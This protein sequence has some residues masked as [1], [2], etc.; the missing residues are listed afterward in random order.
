MLA[1]PPDV[2]PNLPAPDHLTARLP[3]LPDHLEDKW[4]LIGHIHWCLPSE[5]Y[6]R[7]RWTINRPFPRKCDVYDPSYFIVHPGVF[8]PI[9]RPRYISRSSITS[10]GYPMN[11]SHAAQVLEHRSVVFAFYTHSELQWVFAEQIYCLTL[12]IRNSSFGICLYMVVHGHITGGIR[13]QI[14][15]SLSVYLKIWAKETVV[16]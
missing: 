5:V 14:T 13:C 6:R 4:Y 8:C 3:L 2:V 10:G 15:L 12:H 11:P 16:W 1:A 7:L 9:E